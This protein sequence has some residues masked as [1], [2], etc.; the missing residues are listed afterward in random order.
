[1]NCPI[2]CSELLPRNAGPAGPF[3]AGVEGAQPLVG[4]FEGAKPRQA[5][6]TA[7]NHKKSY[8]SLPKPFAKITYTIHVGI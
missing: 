1:M 3:P 5:Y 2:S 8:K 6:F 7:D 4:K